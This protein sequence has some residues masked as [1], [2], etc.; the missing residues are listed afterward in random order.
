METI[1]KLMLGF[2][3]AIIVALSYVVFTGTDEIVRTAL[4]LT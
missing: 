4:D 2:F 1:D 3:I